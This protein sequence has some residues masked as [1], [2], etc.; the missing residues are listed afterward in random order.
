MSGGRRIRHVGMQSGHPL[1]SAYGIELRCPKT[2]W[3]KAKRTLSFRQKTKARPI[4][5]L[6]ALFMLPDFRLD[7]GMRDRHRV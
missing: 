2:F 4:N 3:F 6:G 5:F 1:E 7:L